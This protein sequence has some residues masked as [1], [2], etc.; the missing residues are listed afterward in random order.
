MAKAKETRQAPKKTSEEQTYEH[1][2]IMAEAELDRVRR[3]LEETKE[4][5]VAIREESQVFG[6]LKKIEYDQTHNQL[7]KYTALA[8]LKERKGYRKGGLTWEQFCEAIGEPVRTVDQTLK[9]LKPLFDQFSAGFA[10]LPIFTGLSF[11]KIK[12]LGKAISANS[13][14]IQDGALVV[15]GVKVPLLPEN[16]EEIETL[17]DGLKETH[18]QE[19]TTL[20]KK[21]DRMERGLENAIK[22]ET[23]NLQL[24]KEALL[25]E[26]KRMKAF[27]PQDKDRTWSIEQAKVLEKTCSEFVICCS[28]FI[29]DER[30][31]DDRHLQ[32]LV[33][34]HLSEAQDSLYDLRGRFDDMF[35][36]E[37]I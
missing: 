14:E 17:I 29:M 8:R 22:E 12:Y 37:H 2:K 32:A 5:I 27:D 33:N 36:Y 4:G 23:H 13:A 31:I 26:N 3:E 21:L 28:R 20:E 24:E 35:G 15:D 10:G 19:K 11:S 18:R 34:K 9:D 25:K 7:L 16:A 6:M 30:I 1:M